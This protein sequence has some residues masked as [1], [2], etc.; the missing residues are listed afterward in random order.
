MEW[1]FF[2]LDDAIENA[3]TTSS[4]TEGKRIETPWG[5]TYETYNNKRSLRIIRDEC[6]RYVRQSREDR[7]DID[8]ILSEINILK[9]TRNMDDLVVL[10]PPHSQLQGGT[11]SEI[12]KTELYY[13]RRSDIVP[14]IPT[15]LTHEEWVQNLQIEIEN[16]SDDYDK[17]VFE[18]MNFRYEVTNLRNRL[19]DFKKKMHTACSKVRK[20]R[21]NNAP[22]PSKSSATALFTRFLTDRE[23]KNAANLLLLGNVD[24]S[25]FIIV[26]DKNQDLHALKILSKTHDQ[27]KC[28]SLYGKKVEYLCNYEKGVVAVN[29]VKVIRPLDLPPQE[30]LIKQWVSNLTEGEE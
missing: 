14:T 28:I 18:G 19:I 20:Q 27:L 3:P 29:G 25:R 12:L 7:E 6:A 22:K 24:M 30:H 2:D 1:F 4:A 15:I 21:I 13:M 9:T 5:K 8:Y 17:I 23:Y 11:L 26:Y 10:R 16:A